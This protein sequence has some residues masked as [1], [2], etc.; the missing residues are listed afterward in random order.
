MFDRPTFDRPTTVFI[1]AAWSQLK[2]GGGYI[3][4]GPPFK[5]KSQLPHMLMSIIQKIYI[6]VEN[7]SSVRLTVL[8]FPNGVYFPKHY[9]ILYIFDIFW[10]AFWTPDNAGVL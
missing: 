1:L 3:F 10:K 7:T 2:N 4:R 6:H 5:I 9:L 8:H